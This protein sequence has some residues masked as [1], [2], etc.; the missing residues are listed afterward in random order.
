MRVPPEDKNSFYVA[1]P[2]S[3]KDVAQEIMAALRKNGG[4]ITHDW[5]T[6][7]PIKPY[8]D[9]PKQA[10]EYAKADING[11]S[12]CHTFIMLPEKEG[13]TTLFAELGAAIVSS[14][15]KR[16]FIVGAHNERAIAFFHPKAKRLDTIEEVFKLL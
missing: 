16:I 4:T 13:G 7:L 8:G 6:H 10:T 12:N 1:A 9:N 3:K 15:V 2:F 5:T 11:A 14:K